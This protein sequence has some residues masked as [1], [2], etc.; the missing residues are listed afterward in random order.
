MSSKP[1]P[2]RRRYIHDRV[3]AYVDSRK[4]LFA[5]GEIEQVV[6]YLDWQFDNF[7]DPSISKVEGD[8]NGRS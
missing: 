4:G 5:D 3:K 2:D 8:R 7:P 6:K 1:V